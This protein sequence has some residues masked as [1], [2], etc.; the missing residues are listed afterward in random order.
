MN[1]SSGNNSSHGK[2]LKCNQN[3]Q[4]YLRLRPT[5][6]REKLIRSQEVVEIVSSKEVLLKPMILDTRNAKKFTFDRAF[7]VNSKQHEVYNAVVAPYIEEVLA[8]FNCTVFAYGQ[9]GTGK[10]YTMVGEEQPELSA[11]W[12]DD[13]Q[14][15]IIPRALNHLFDELRMTE[16]EFSMRI[17]Y[18]ELYNEELCDLL[19]TDDTVKIRIYDDVNK[20]G[21]V[22]VQGLEEIPVHSKDDVYKL[23]AKGQD[24]RRTASTLMNAQ[25]S[26]SHTIFSIIVHI[27]ENGIEGEELLKI[28]KLNLVDLAGSENITKAGNEKGIRTRETVN[29]NQSLLTLGRVIT[30]LV[31]RTP[32]IPYR[33]SK[34]TRLLQ[35]SLGGRTKTSIIATISPG[36]KDFEETMSTLEYAHRAKNI[37]NKP[38]ANQKLSKKTVIKEYTEEIDR[39]KRELMATRDKNGIYL[40]EET[41][42]EMLYKS[43]STTKELNDKVVLIKLLKEDLAKK[44]A[45]FKEVSLNL[46][47][48]EDILRKTEGDLSLT[49][50]ELTTTKR[51][52]NKTKRRY[53][54]KKV[55]LERHVETEEAL[56]GQAKELIE[57]VE[58]VQSDAKGLHDTIDRRK[59][60]DMKN[61]TVCQQFVEQIKNRVKIMQA[62][63]TNLTQD[64]YQI[65]NALAG[66][67]ENYI[68]KQESFQQ[69]M[70]TKLSALETLSLGMLSKDSD[71]LAKFR[72][73]QTNWNMEQIKQVQEYTDSIDRSVK[74]LLTTLAANTQSLKRTLAEQEEQQKNMLETVLQACRRN[75][76]SNLRFC[77]AQKESLKMI[78]ELAEQFGKSKTQIDEIAI[79]SQRANEQRKEKLMKIMEQM[80]ELE[81][82][83]LSEEQELVRLRTI[84]RDV[85]TNNAS[86]VSTIA[87]NTETID[88][89]VRS[90]QEEFKQLES[91]IRQ[92]DSTRQESKSIIEGRLQNQIIQP[93]ETTFTHLKETVSQQK[94]HFKTSEEIFRIRWEDFTAQREQD[95]TEFI[96][97]H[98]CQREALQKELR[99][100]YA[101]QSEFRNTT[102]SLNKRLQSNITSHQQ[103]TD[104]SLAELCDQVDRFHR[105]ELVLYQ[106]TGQTPARKTISY[107]KDIAMT[108]PHDRIVRRFWR[109]RGMMDLDVSNIINEDN[110]DVSVLCTSLNSDEIRNSTPLATRYNVLDEDQKRF[111][112]LQFSTILSKIGT[113]AECEENKENMDTIVEGV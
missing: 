22:I 48:K 80:K 92:L 66:D 89:N 84:S 51:T 55:I 68:E 18:L 102:V 34:L 58:T 35:E 33:E 85:E 112:D 3:V 64:C 43:E 29:I 108:S 24:R 81:L 42:N 17:S 113:E 4:V 39:L 109:E 103:Q 46:I 1:A 14:T 45:I 27:K 30:A 47:E 71:V 38:E 60:T 75:D 61:Q 69:D 21:S 59:E 44:E 104:C 31:E 13:T 79:T 57:V 98:K 101:A 36:H 91:D 62:N 11:G 93:M 70:H 15:G 12:D 20:K 32:H 100:N 111:K 87:N 50:H 41:Y 40:P 54:E 56:T 105:E 19:S 23:L 78:G 88:R 106:P 25:S 5:N 83:R 65:S 97:G 7:D 86:L 74:N 53:A 67:W 8:G 77:T 26:R 99:S 95:Q 6:T 28:G 73:D 82:D 76:E 37:Q 63:T 10:T 9:T 96:A 2:P 110:E 49:K 94:E 107:P 52:L 16:L 72:L 90:Q